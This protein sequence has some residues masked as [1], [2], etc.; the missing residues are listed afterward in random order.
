MTDQFMYKRAAGY[1]L[2]SKTTRWYN[3]ETVQFNSWTGS[4]VPLSD[5]NFGGQKIY[6]Y[7]TFTGATL[8]KKFPFGTFASV[9]TSSFDWSAAASSSLQAMRPS[10]SEVLA[11]NLLLELVEALRILGPKAKKTLKEVERRRSKAFRKWQQY[12]ERE[13]RNKIRRI[14]GQKPLPSRLRNPVPDA[15]IWGRSFN[16][17]GKAVS[18][19]AWLNLAWQFAV[20]PTLQDAKAIATI[21]ESLE[22]TL[23]DLIRKG[24]DL[25]VRHYKRPADIITLPPKVRASTQSYEGDTSTEV[26]RTYEWVLRPTYRASMY[27]TYDTTKLQAMVGKIQSMVNALGVSKIASV[28]W[29][30]IPYSFVVD[31]FVNVGDLIDSVEDSILDPLPIVVHDFTHSLKYGHRAIATWHFQNYVIDIYRETKSFYERRRDIPS[32]WDSLSVHSPNLNQVG[33]GLSLIIAKMD[34]VTRKR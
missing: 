8:F 4:T 12:L 5:P 29:E 15:S 16:F 1:C 22:K 10:L 21:I 25:Q 34:G 32:L 23:S 31:W 33:L 9:T 11:P 3:G 17:I 20:R 6:R 18:T 14:K 28:I 24:N 27:F 30:A 13:R 26:W 7:H 19:F 2:H